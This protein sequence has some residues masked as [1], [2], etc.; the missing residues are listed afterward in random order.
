MTT[1]Q[2][3]NAS[4]KRDACLAELNTFYEEIETSIEQEDADELNR[5][6]DS[7]AAVLKRLESLVRI[8]PLSKKEHAHLLDREEKLQANFQRALTTFKK[9]LGN[10]RRRTGAITKYRK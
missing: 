5:L 9:R 7:R 1:D 3:I 6:I 4:A 8:A 2:N 10:S